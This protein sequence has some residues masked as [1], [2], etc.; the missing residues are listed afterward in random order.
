MT[1]PYKLNF[2]HDDDNFDDFEYIPEIHYYVGQVI[3]PEYRLLIPKFYIKLGANFGLDVSNMLLNRI[4]FLE[5]LA[6]IDRWYVYILFD[7]LRT[8]DVE[9]ASYQLDYILNRDLDVELE[10]KEPLLT[11]NSENEFPYLRVVYNACFGYNYLHDA[12]EGEV[13]E[14]Q[15]GEVVTFYVSHRLPETIMRYL[16]ISPFFSDRSLEEVQEIIN[17]PEIAPID[18]L[19]NYI[20]SF[21]GIDV[22]ENVIVDENA[23]VKW[24]EYD[25]VEE[26]I[27]D[28]NL[29]QPQEDFSIEYLRN[30]GANIDDYKIG[31]LQEIAVA[32]T[33]L[34]EV[35][36]TH[37]VPGV[38]YLETVFNYFAYINRPRRFLLIGPS[39]QFVMSP[40]DFFESRINTVNLDIID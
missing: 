14:D 15:D 18:D 32:D 21:A 24:P 31:T 39:V 22:K 16:E 27:K 23:E 34:Q 13:I 36:D 29:R 20:L 38:Q 5:N 40:F 28:K 33:K 10:R 17:I 2:Y 4:E 12:G 26:Y 19:F 3:E 6:N 8:K 25:S 9:E 7:A 35:F 37:N 1:S 11:L 30:V